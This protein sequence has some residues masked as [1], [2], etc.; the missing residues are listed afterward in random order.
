ME[1][2]RLLLMKKKKKELKEEREK[3]IELEDYNRRE[4]LKFHNSPESNLEGDT[5]SA[6]QVILDILEKELRIDTTDIR[7]QAAHRIGKRKESR[8]YW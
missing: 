1:G 4:N 8:Y 7:F 5:Q 2:L 6:E 3:I